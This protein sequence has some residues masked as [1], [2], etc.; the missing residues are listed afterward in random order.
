M[1][2]FN[3]VKASTARLSAELRHM[4]EERDALQVR[5]HT[6]AAHVLLVCFKFYL[7]VVPERTTISLLS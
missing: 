5:A 4:K 1:A 6:A 3:A 7:I 2:E